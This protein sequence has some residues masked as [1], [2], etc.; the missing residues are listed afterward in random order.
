[1]K[2]KQKVNYLIQHPAL[3]SPLAIIA[4]MTTTLAATVNDN[5]FTQAF[6]PSSVIQFI[7]NIGVKYLPIGI[8]AGLLLWLIPADDRKKQMGKTMKVNYLIQH[9]A[10]MSPLAIIASM[11]TTL[12]ATVNDNL[13]T[14]AFDPSS[15][16]QFIANIGVKYLPIGIIAGLLLWLIPADDRK[17]QM[18]K[19]MVISM[20]IAFA[21]CLLA[22]GD[23]DI[24]NKIQSLIESLRGSTTS[25][26][27]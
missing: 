2:I 4:S 26:K 9:P 21:I 5:L 11:T 3:M 6:D 7:A 17:K 25:K 18:G 1:M 12:A 16:I 10:L 27:P 22:A 23:T 14:Q 15:V 13:F 24:A 8:I 20:T 19:T